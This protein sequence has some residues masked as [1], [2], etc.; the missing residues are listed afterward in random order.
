MSYIGD[1][2]F[3]GIIVNIIISIFTFYLVTF[4]IQKEFSLIALSTIIITRILFSFLLFDDYKLSWSKASTKTG[5]MKIILALISFM[6]YMP[7]LYY[8]YAVSFN[9][10]FI[11]LIFYTFIINILV[12]VYKYYHSVGKNKKTKNLVIYG[13]GKAGLQ[14]QREFLSSEYKLICF[15]DDDEIL[16]HRSID[17]ISIYSKEK[18]CSL[19]E[20]QKFDLMI[21]AMPSAS[22][23]QIKIIYEFMQDKFEKIKILP[24]MNNIL[25]KEEFTKQLKDIGVEDLLARYP[26]DLDKKQI[27]NFIKDKIVLITGAGGSIGSEISRQCKAYGAKQLILLDHSEFN[28]YSILEE[29]K[30]EN[31]VPIMQSVRDIKALE[32]TFEK[33][34]PQIVIHAAAYKHVPLV[35]YNILEGIT[36]NIIG[37]KNCIDLSIKYGAQKFVL[38]STDKAVRPTNIMGT[39]KR[40]CEL[41]AQN[42]E[43]K[44]TEIVAVRFGN[45]LGSSGSVIPKFKSQIEQ[46]KNITVTHPEITRYFMLIPEACELVLQ[47][48]SI[49]K[50]GEIFILDMGEPIKIVDLAKKMI[51]LSG[52]SDIN[53]EF[54]GLRLGEK[55]YEELLINDSDQKTKYESITVANST[56]FDIKELSKKIEELL[57]C[58]DKVAKLKEIVPEFEHRLNN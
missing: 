51:E 16:H 26:K 42:V 10:L 21:I 12:Y 49:G 39:T 52:R 45:V 46:G 32:S 35:E 4:L 30:D 5:L 34:K 40:I 15:I 48:A 3:L 1:K 25:K 23:E 19:F 33:Y 36:N 38:I 43:S 27:E 7:I 41:Y 58:E 6:I 56:K 17:G 47:A 44:N 29:L 37:T 13:A 24:S 55:L 50:G 9:L 2:R 53:I 11:D 20:D 22:Q 18:Y 14:L 28:L 31:I 54:C 57:I 8:F